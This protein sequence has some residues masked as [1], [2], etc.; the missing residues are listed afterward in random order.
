MSMASVHGPQMAEFCTSI[1]RGNLSLSSSLSDLVGSPIEITMDNVIS[2]EELRAQ[3]VSCFSCGVTWTDD[4]VSLDCKECG[5]Y[6][7]ERP[8]PLCDGKC[9]VI[10]K[11]DFTMS[12]ACSKARWHGVCPM[13]PEATFPVLSLPLNGGITS[14][15]ISTTPASCSATASQIHLAQELCAR[16][17][18][19]SASART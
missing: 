5:G 16:L 11:R 2:I 19:L 13:F 3:M 9:G 4:H 12:H 6:S 7:L 10:W 8:C 1:G 14:S 18:Q 17:E 15:S